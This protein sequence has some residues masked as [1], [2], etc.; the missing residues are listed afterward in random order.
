MRA[1]PNWKAKAGSPEDAVA[2]IKSGMKV[3]IHR[4]AATPTPLLKAL[5][6]RPDLADVQ[7]YHLHV[8]GDIPFADPVHRQIETHRKNDGPGEHPDKPGEHKSTDGAQKDDQH[9]HGGT[10]SHQ[11]RFQHIVGQA[12]G[13]QQD[14][15]QE[16]RRQLF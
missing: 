8:S 3:F 1:D 12:D 9:R 15:P 2:H 14:R 5:C 7:L 16:R 6:N 11:Q 13:Q 4:A 10:F